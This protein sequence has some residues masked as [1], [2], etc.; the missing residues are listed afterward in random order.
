MAKWLHLPSP[1]AI[2][3]IFVVEA[4]INA[5]W[6]TMTQFLVSNS[7]VRDIG[8][9]VLSLA[10]LFAVAWYLRNRR[11]NEPAVVPEVTRPEAGSNGAMF[12]PQRREYSWFRGQVES[13]TEV[14]AFWHVGTSAR[15]NGL[16]RTGRIKRLLLLYQ[17]NPA[18]KTLAE[19]THVDA[20]VLRREI[21]ETF[22]AAHRLSV[23][24]KVWE[25]YAATP[26]TIGNPTQSG[27]QWV[28]TEHLIPYIDADKRPANYITDQQV[29]DRYRE[30]FLD[31]WG[32]QQLTAATNYYQF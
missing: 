8:F 17:D 7:L 16:F 19:A 3:H 30:A 31:M 25:G 26:F 12:H 32:N 15:N 20:G 5:G 6:W 24:V 1:G 2:V 23:E 13:A 28:I 29:C 22:Q 11:P 21:E 14:W 4:L 9:L 10:A 18:L 27:A